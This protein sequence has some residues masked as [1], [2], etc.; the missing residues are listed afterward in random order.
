MSAVKESDEVAKVTPTDSDNNAS[1]DSQDIKTML[2]QF[3]AT[4][5]QIR[6]ADRLQ[7]QNDLADLRA[8][9][10]SLTQH[11]S[12][13]QENYP[14]QTPF[15]DRRTDNRRSS[16]FFGTPINSKLDANAKPQ[17]QVL[18]AD[19]IYDRELKV[20]SLEGLQ[21][22]AKQIALLSSKYPGR[23]IKVAHMVSYN[24]RPH[25]IAAWNSFCHKEFLISGVEPEEVMVE[26]WLSLSNDS[27]NAML[28][29]AA[30]PRTRELYSR[31]L[32]IFLGKGIPQSPDVNSENF[33]KLF[34]VPLMKSLNDLLHLHDLLSEDT[35]NHSNNLS[36]MPSVTYGTRDSPGHIALWIISL[37]T[38]KDAILQ[39]LGK[40]ELNKFKT[41]ELAVKFIRSRLMDTRA[42]SEARQ[43]LD[44]KLTPIR[45]EDIRHTQGESYQRQQVHKPSRHSLNTPDNSRFRDPKSRSTFAALQLAQD[46][47]KTAEDI[48]P[49]YAEEFHDEDEVDNDDLPSYNEDEDSEDSKDYQRHITTN[50]DSLNATTDSTFR[51]A[52]GS[53]SRGYCSE[54]FV[55]GKCPRRDA[56]CIFD[57][58]AAGHEKCLQSFSLLTKRELLTHSQLPPWQTDTNVKK[59]IF[60]QNRVFKTNSPPFGQPRSYGSPPASHNS[61]P[62]SKPSGY[63]STPYSK[64]TGYNSTPYPRHQGGL[65]VLKT[66]T[67]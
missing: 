2:S 15:P 6:N 49:E 65:S 11:N 24:L 30:R 35:S 34:Y 29:E 9:I 14:I 52:L 67:K 33:S 22:L 36:K 61:T 27:V 60:S 51:S 17:I 13:H 55:F 19:I 57:H 7:N 12:E 32:V 56:G 5:T 20:S 42:Q 50:V 23:D 8:S 26:D 38:Q 37:G 48:Y 28:L 64:S 16:M 1:K 3:I 4:S 25:I 21:Y 39:W 53:T 63:N 58:S 54:L 43:D 47:D 10:N 62:H 31:E 18:Q 40:D 45:Y 66:H 46:P 44:A 59:P 41:V